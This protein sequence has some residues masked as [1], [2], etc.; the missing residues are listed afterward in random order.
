MEQKECMQGRRNLMVPFY[1]CKGNIDPDR[2]S[3]ESTGKCSRQRSSHSPSFLIVNLRLHMS[4]FE[5]HVLSFP[6]GVNS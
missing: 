4:H 6:C 3:R 1:E 2:L 5:S